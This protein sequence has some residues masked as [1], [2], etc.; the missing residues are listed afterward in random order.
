MICYADISLKNN[1]SKPEL[2]EENMLS[3]ENGRHPLQEIC[4]DTFIPNDTLITV[5]PRI[6]FITGANYSGKS[7]YMKQVKHLKMFFIEWL[8]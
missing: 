8:H 5:D 7:V 4:C 1:Y 6:H 3:I 2:V